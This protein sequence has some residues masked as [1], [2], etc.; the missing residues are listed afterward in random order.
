[1]KNACCIRSP[2]LLDGGGAE[3]EVGVWDVCVVI[4]LKFCSCINNRS[5][6][7]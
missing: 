2:H 1:M 6:V 3:S 4:T 7:I 5:D